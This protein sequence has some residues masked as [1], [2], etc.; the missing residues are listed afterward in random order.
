MLLR[1]VVGPTCVVDVQLALQAPYLPYSID[2]GD[3][4][5]KLWALRRF[6]V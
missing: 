5:A 2:N 4:A 1:A 6:G 3:V